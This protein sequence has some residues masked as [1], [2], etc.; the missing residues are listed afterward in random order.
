MTLS[1]ISKITISLLTILAIFSLSNCSVHTTNGTSLKQKEL[2]PG[3]AKK[4]YGGKSAKQYAP[5]QN[6]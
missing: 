3:Q 5:G 1:K 4:I 2:P 6:K